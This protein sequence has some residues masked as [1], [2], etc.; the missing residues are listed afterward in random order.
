MFGR[1]FLCDHPNLGLYLRGI[2]FITVL[3]SLL[4]ISL[5]KWSIFF[6]LIIGRLYVYR[7]FSIS[8]GF[9]NLLAHNSVFLCV[10]ISLWYR[11]FLLFSLFESSLL[12]L[13]NLA[14]NFHFILLKNQLWFHLFYFFV[15][16]NLWSLLFPHFC[17]LWALFFFFEFLYVVG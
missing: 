2:F 11:L 7:S 1:I 10:I 16:L 17:W 6:W 12:Y 3:I 5:C 14:K 15:S 8:S 13:I 9:S 4:V